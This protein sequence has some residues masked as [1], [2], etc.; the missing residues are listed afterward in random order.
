MRWFLVTCFVMQAT[1][2]ATAA[3]SYTNRTLAAVSLLPGNSTD[4]YSLLRQG[5]PKKHQANPLFV[6]TKPWENRLDN[7]YPNVILDT[8]GYK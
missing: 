5:Q 2:V 1:L 6:Q 3:E 4:V 7:G 8:D